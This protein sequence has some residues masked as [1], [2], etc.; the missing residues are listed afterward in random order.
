METQELELVTEKPGTHWHLC[1]KPECRHAWRHSDSNS[2]VL[3]SHVCLKCGSM[4][5]WKEKVAWIREEAKSVEI[6]D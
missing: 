2:G 1:E 5:F 3:L 4:Q 6:C